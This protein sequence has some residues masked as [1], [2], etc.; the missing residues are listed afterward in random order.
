M[1]ALSLLLG[2][3]LGVLQ[4]LLTR[5]PDPDGRDSPDPFP[6]A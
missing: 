2:L 3:P 4:A 5:R 1:T 6:I